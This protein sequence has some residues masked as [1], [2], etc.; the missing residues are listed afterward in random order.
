MKH[1]D[2]HAHARNLTIGQRVMVRNFR[3]GPHWIPGTVV[4]QNGPLTYL[5]KVRENQVWKRHIDH[6]CQ[7][8]DTP[9]EL[10]K[11]NAADLNITEN[12]FNDTSVTDDDFTDEIADAGTRETTG[13]VAEPV[14]SDIR[15]YPQRTCRPPDRL[16]HQDSI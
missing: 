1:H 7:M 11:S 8:E 6:V 14:D 15:R 4:K 16:I 5:V 9:R 13:T 2:S 12:E 3:T 10:S